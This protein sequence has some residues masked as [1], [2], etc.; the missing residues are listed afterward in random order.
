MLVLA[1]VSLFLP[2]PALFSVLLSALV[3]ELLLVLELVLF[4]ALS[5]CRCRRVGGGASTCLAARFFFPA[6]PPPPAAPEDEEEGEEEVGVDAIGASPTAP[7]NGWGYSS[8]RLVRV[9]TTGAPPKGSLATAR[10]NRLWIR[11]CGRVC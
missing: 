3:L 5:I 8:M 7:G 2:A 11:G 10:R 4:L 1:L 9:P 6:W